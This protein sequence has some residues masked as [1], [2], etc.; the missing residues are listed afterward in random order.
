M[1]TGKFGLVVVITSEM[2][3]YLLRYVSGLVG[4][5]GTALFVCDFPA[6]GEMKVVGSLDP[7]GSVGG[8]CEGG[9]YWFLVAGLQGQQSWWKDG[10]G[11]LRRGFV[12]SVLRW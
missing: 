11:K 6:C 12:G 8:I 9:G 4:K 1:N 3:W 5:L 10:A 2:K 7:H